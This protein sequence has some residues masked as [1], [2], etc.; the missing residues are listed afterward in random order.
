[1]VERTSQTSSGFWSQI[2]EYDV[3]ATW[4]N[5]ER[6]KDYLIDCTGNQEPNQMD[7][8]AI[9]ALSKKLRQHDQNLRELEDFIKSQSLIT[10]KT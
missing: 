10:L 3:I 1:M 7:G 8:V 4:H 5:A 9:K 6:L 2:A